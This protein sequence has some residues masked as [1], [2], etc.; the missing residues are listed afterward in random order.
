MITTFDRSYWIG[1][2]DT[3]FVMAANRTTKTWLT[4]YNI[5]LGL[6]DTLFGGSIYTRMGNLFEHPILKAIDENMNTDRQLIIPKY[7]LR[8]N[9]DG[10]LNGSIYEVKTHRG[11]KNFEVSKQYYEQ[12]Q[13][14]MFA[15]KQYL[16]DSEHYCDWHIREHL[17]PFEKLTIVSYA[18]NVEEYSRLEIYERGEAEIEIDKSRIKFHEIKYDKGF[19]S[20]YKPAVKSLAKKIRNGDTPW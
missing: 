12:A 4:W 16:K 20:K 9:Y 1:A 19:I 6:D 14:E 11:D 2:S 3:R 15:W 8:V 18:L 7:N 17:E 5:K 13:V 10:D